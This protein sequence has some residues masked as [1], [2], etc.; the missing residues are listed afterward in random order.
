M[1]ALV[2]VQAE[3]LLMEKQPAMVLQSGIVVMWQI[4]KSY[5]IIIIIILFFLLVILLSTDTESNFTGEK[6][7]QNDLLLSTSV[8]LSD[9]N[10]HV[11]IS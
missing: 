11:C 3:F 7:Q 6:K 1:C 9:Y 5:F 8:H 2:G 10:T 4:P